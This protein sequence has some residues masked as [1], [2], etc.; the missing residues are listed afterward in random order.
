MRVPC[1]FPA[2]ALALLT[3]P[4][5]AAAPA[6]RNEIV[7]DGAPDFTSTGGS[8]SIVQGNI[9]RL[10]AD[11]GL[12]G[13]ENSSDAEVG[14]RFTPFACGPATVRFDGIR[15]VGRL[16]GFGNINA[17]SIRVEAKVRDLTDDVELASESVLHKSENGAPFTGTIQPV[18]EL[19]LAPTT[20]EVELA[21]GHEYAAYIRVVVRANGTRGFSDFRSGSDNQ[22]VPPA[23]GVALGSVAIALDLADSDGDGLYDVWETE[24]LDLDCDPSNGIDVDLP[25]MGADPNHKDLFLEIDW[26]PD[27]PPTRGMVR[28]LKRAFALAP[29][30]AGGVLNP[31]RT[32]GITVHVDTGDLFDPAASE[33]GAALGSCGDGIDNDGDG[34]VDG[35]D[36]DCWVGD[37]AFHSDGG[38]LGRGTS[39]P[40]ANVSDM[41]TDDDGDGVTNYYESR[42]FDA[43]RRSAFRYAISAPRVGSLLG[44]AELGGND[45]LVL[46]ETQLG[47]ACSIGAPFPSGTNTAAL[48][49]E[50]GH[51]LGL[52]HSGDSGIPGNEVNYLSVMN[53]AQALGI[54]QND[55]DTS[56]DLDGDGIVD[57]RIIDYS[58]PRTR[59]GR[60]A[61]PIPLGSDPVDGV[62]DEDDLDENLVLDPT[63]DSNRM[64]FYDP[65][66][67]LWRDA[68][69]NEPQDWDG[70]GVPGE[71]G[72]TADLNNNGQFDRFVGFNDWDNIL[73][74]QIGWEDS[75]ERPVHNLGQLQI[76]DGDEMLEIYRQ[77]SSTDLTVGIERL[78]PFVV[79]GQPLDYSITVTNAGVNR[80]RFRLRFE[81]PPEARFRGASSGCQPNA[82]GAIVCESGEQLEPGASAVHLVQLRLPADLECAGAQFRTLVGEAR[83]ELLTG[84][85]L[86]P[87]NNAVARTEEALCIAYEYAAA[88]TCG[89]QLLATPLSRGRYAT[90]VNVHNPN[91][92]EVHFFKKLALTYPPAAQAPGKVLPIAV[93]RLGYD[94]A[95]KSE[96][97]E[98]LR[99]AAD[100]AGSTPFV[101]GFLVIQSP[102]SL[103]VTA[104]YSVTTSQT[105]LHVEQIR[106]RKR[107]RSPQEPPHDPPRT[108]PDLVPEELDP[109]DPQVQS[110]GPFCAF[111]AGT[112]NG[113]LL[114][115]VANRGA[116]DAAGST[117]RVTFLGASDELVRTEDVA[118]PAVP[119]GG[120]I[121]LEV[122]VPDGWPQGAAG[123]FGIT[124]DQGNAVPDESNEGNNAVEGR[125][126]LPG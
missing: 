90:S 44:E 43:T 63:D 62:L 100:A 14:F 6:P 61:A 22:P 8:N 42:R 4:L 18:T 83:V 53:V 68:P 119:A 112:Q 39:I 86:D 116:G 73:L 70:D 113:V 36:S 25:A 57:C 1:P 65:V 124:V 109:N 108:R 38:G 125:C 87:T 103:D 46:Q 74:S 78:S 64:V 7:L 24:G 91:D 106:E 21:A 88:I 72:V 31:D 50:L 26:M 40:A 120:S 60:A 79:A 97:T 13:T 95:L 12:A 52:L 19:F 27:A 94:E 123:S 66:A 54:V 89:E 35:D 98:L 126:F 71:T 93:D 81:P 118:T 48:M 30:S 75:D 69:V 41:R 59:D 96:C 5:L 77:R 28:A 56:Q 84:P 76:D 114:V 17:G 20:L 110:N 101:E 33:S 3:A 51:T 102:R 67:E 49:H 104:A 105:N 80:G 115:R 58:P 29:E 121:V 82:S 9:A 122:P 15:A 47:T 11:G 37:A 111:K 45:F 16:R 34:L 92:E 117:T 32:D 99:L 107:Q 23:K 10:R 2:V 55:P 85:D